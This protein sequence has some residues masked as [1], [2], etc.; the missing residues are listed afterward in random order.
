MQKTNTRKMVLCAIFS[1]IIVA[2]TVIPYTGY[3]NYAGI[4]EITTLHIVVILGAIALGWRYGA[5]LGGV[6]GITCVLRALTNPLWYPFIN[7]LI[8][9]VPRI[10]VGLVAGLV[11]MALRKKIA[12]VP[13]AAVAALAG[14][15]T[16]TVLVLTALNLFS[17]MVKWDFFEQFKQFFVAIISINGG[18]ELVAA[19]IIAPVL[20]TAVLGQM[21]KAKG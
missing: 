5:F 11:F 21:D 17:D 15:L 1:A 12:L 7:P 4:I 6:W 19:I 2:F 16:N 3:I 20:A 10:F 13:S 14:S 8:S 9:V 18:I